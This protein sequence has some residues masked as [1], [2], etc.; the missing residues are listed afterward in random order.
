VLTPL[1]ELP[2]RCQLVLISEKKLAAPFAA[3]DALASFTGFNYSKGEHLKMY[4]FLRKEI[5]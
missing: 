4:L 2:E 3:A 5:P 1:A